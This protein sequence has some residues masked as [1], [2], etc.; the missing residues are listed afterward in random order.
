MRH[1]SNWKY[2]KQNSDL[3]KSKIKLFSL[4]FII[5]KCFMY[6]YAAVKLKER[7]NHIP[8][9]DEKDCVHRYFNSM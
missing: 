4:G 7:G 1:F 2:S 6:F 5:N 8:K 9:K 3:S